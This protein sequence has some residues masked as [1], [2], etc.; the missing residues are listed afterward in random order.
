VNRALI[1]PPTAQP[2][3]VAEAMLAARLDEPHWEPEVQRAIAEGVALAE[4]ETGRRVMSQ[5]WRY[6]LQ[7]WPDKA[8]VLPEY[9]PT[10]VAITYRDPAGTWLTLS[11]VTYLWAPVRDGIV[12]APVAGHSYPAIAPDEFGDAVRV[13][14]TVGA[15]NA[16]AVPAA[17]R[18]FVLGVVA[19]RVPGVQGDPAAQQ[20][21]YLIAG[22]DP[23]RLYK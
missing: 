6:T 1:S 16:A 18:S 5:T 15:G 21:R 23:L 9:Q 12:I 10:N 3:T 13:D 22:L 14:I 20:M 11:N 4:H 2:V 8:D 17:L 19:L 7:A